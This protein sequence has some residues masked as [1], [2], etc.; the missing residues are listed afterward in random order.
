MI[1]VAFFRKKESAQWFLLIC[2][3]ADIKKQTRSD[4]GESLLFKILIANRHPLIPL[5]SAAAAMRK[6]P[7]GDPHFHTA[8]DRR[9]G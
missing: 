6:Q 5:F 4:F 3:L 1:A 9:R 8:P 2:C 7:A